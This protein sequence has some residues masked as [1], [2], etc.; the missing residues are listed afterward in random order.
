MSDTYKCCVENCI[1]TVNKAKTNFSLKL[2]NGEI[3]NAENLLLEKCDRCGEVY[4]DSDASVCLETEIKKKYPNYF[5]KWE[6]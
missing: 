4:F 5:K 3:F 1:G 2:S 6:K